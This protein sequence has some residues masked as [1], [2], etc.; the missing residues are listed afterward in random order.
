MLSLMLLAGCY[1]GPPAYPQAVVAVA[2]APVFVFPDGVDAYYDPAYGTYVYG[3]GGFYYRWVGGGWV[4]TASWGGYW[5]P[6]PPAVFLPPLLVYG[7]PPPVVGYRPYFIWWRAR[8]GGWYAVHH[9]LWWE[10]HERYLRHYQLWHARV[11]TFY[12]RHPGYRPRMRPVFHGRARGPV[13]YGY[14]RGDVRRGPYEGDR[15]DGRPRFGGRAER[16]Y[17]RGRGGGRGH[18]RHG[19]CGP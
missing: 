5:R 12:A 6:L 19:D 2:P 14:D 16:G 10:R 18:C 1:Y 3:D 17:G 13:R 4:Y 9:P 8:V 7:P 15:P 11:V